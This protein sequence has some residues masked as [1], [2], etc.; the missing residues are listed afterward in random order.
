M[1]DNVDF[2][3]MRQE[4]FKS[5]HSHNKLKTKHYN[6]IYYERNIKSRTFN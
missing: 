3:F 2:R 1:Y 5:T 6:T 4:W